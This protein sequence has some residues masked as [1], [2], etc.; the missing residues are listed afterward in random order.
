MGPGDKSAFQCREAGSSL[1][2]E[3][4]SHMCAVLSHSVVSNFLRLHELQPT[5]LLCS[6]GFSRQES[7]SGL[8]CPSPGMFPTQGSN[9]GLL[10]CRWI[11]YQLSYQGSPCSEANKPMCHSYWA[12]V[13]LSPC[14]TTGES[15]HHNKTTAHY[16]TKILHDP[17][18]RTKTQHSQTNE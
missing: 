13:L 8:L 16:A 18:Y 3:L 12:R 10:N 2:R 15:T 1:V 9:P 6:W 14:T 7:W 4:R 11:P 5:R 17:S